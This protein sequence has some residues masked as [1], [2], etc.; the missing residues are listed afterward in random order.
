[1]GSLYSLRMSSV[2]NGCLGYKFPLEFS[3]QLFKYS[4]KKLL[5]YGKYVCKE[6]IN[7]EAIFCLASFEFHTLVPLYLTINTK[8]LVTVIQKMWSL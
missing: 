8:L 6:R 4:I 5:H 1:M 2:Y 7:G 3:I